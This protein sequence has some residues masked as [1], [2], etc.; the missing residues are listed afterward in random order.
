MIFILVLLSSIALVILTVAALVRY[1]REPQTPR[2]EIVA[3]AFTAMVSAVSLLIVTIVG[4]RVPVLY[5]TG[6]IAS[7]LLP[8][9]LLK[10]AF[11][12]RGVGSFVR[13]MALPGM[14]AVWTL[15]LIFGPRPPS[16][17]AV[18][19]ALYYTAAGLLSTI[20]FIGAAVQSHGAVRMRSGS[21]AVGTLFYTTFL[22]L[23]EGRVVTG[24][25]HATIPILAAAFDTASAFAFCVGLSPPQRLRLHWARALIPALRASLYDGLSRTTIAEIA[26][27]V[28]G[29]ARVA[30]GAVAAGLVLP[31]PGD[32]RLR[33]YRSDADASELESL[34]AV[35]TVTG[36]TVAYMVSLAMAAPEPPR[37]NNPDAEST[38]ALQGALFVSYPQPPLFAEEAQSAL[39]IAAEESTPLL[40]SAVGSYRLEH[41]A[42]AL[43]RELDDRRST[44]RARSK[45]LSALYRITVEA[46]EA[47]SIDEPLMRAI[48][49]LCEILGFSIGH[50]F[51][52]SSGMPTIMGVTPI[53]HIDE[54]I[55]FADFVNATNELPSLTETGGV[56][57][58]MA[59]RYPQWYSDISGHPGFLRRE[60]AAGVGI[61]TG[62]F[63]PVLVQGTV[64]AVIEL[65][66]QHR[67]P[68][69]LETVEF[70]AN[71]GVQLGRVIERMQTEAFIRERERRF[72][73][74]FE[75]QPGYCFI[76]DAEGNIR[77]NNAS[78]VRG[79][80]Y[81]PNEL[82]GAPLRR[83]FSDESWPSVSRLF[84]R[85]ARHGSFEKFDTEVLTRDGSSRYVA[86]NAATLESVEHPTAEEIIVALTDVTEERRTRLEW[87]RLFELTLDLVTLVDRNGK[88][89]QVNPAWTRTL[90]WP[91][92]ELI[93]HPV[94][95]FLHPEDVDRTEAAR[96]VILDGESVTNYDSR[97][98]K[99]DGSYRWIS[100]SSTS[101][102][103]ESIIL[104][105]GRDVTDERRLQ[106]RLE[107]SEFL[108][109][110]T[111]E[112]AA[113]GVAHVSPDGRF[114]RVNRKF[115]EM[116]GYDQDAMTHITSA[117]LVPAEE[118]EKE[119]ESDER[120]LNGKISSYAFE[121]QYRTAAGETLWISE[122]VSLARS[123]ENEPEYFIV[124]AVDITARKALE[125]QL[126]VT[127]AELD[128]RVT[129]RTEHLHAVNRE[130]E[131]FSYSV[132]H[133]LRAPL[134]AVDG[135]S[136]AIAEDYDELLDETGRDYLG[137]IRRETQ[138]MGRLIDD[139]LSL[140]RLSR[141]EIQRVK[142]DMTAMAVRIIDDLRRDTPERQAL[143]AV[144]DGLTVCADSRL[145]EILLRN[146]LGN[147]WKF[148]GKRSTAQIQIGKGEGGTRPE[149]Y[150]RDNG[151]GFNMAYVDKLFGAFQRL[152][153]TEDFEGTGVGLATVQ[154]IA[155]RHGGAVRAEGAVD[156]GATFYFE[157]GDGRC[158]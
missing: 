130:L 50:A 36:G 126:R 49:I 110:N 143:V 15:A 46:N 137:R 79:L 107:E 108:F 106:H 129:E 147:A 113:A 21:M 112:Q 26:G 86:L 16:P 102:P 66:S 116:L 127:N 58:V 149:F 32:R 59:L 87:N 52:P 124:V 19:T 71:V 61:N 135:F 42:S 17:A 7:A 55:A 99:S 104:A 78:A 77:D 54:D 96:R 41:R 39:S 3:T 119:R 142:V 122:T 146:L 33:L 68:R 70:L 40:Q 5:T 43:E 8:F 128:R 53:W 94:S 31:D 9:F 60:A 154:R 155:H 93:D 56:G 148:T 29:A 131:S 134:R 37:P 48:H 141:S 1:R 90:G 85:L 151:A 125:E 123:Q 156:N 63:V 114:L 45:R 88:I 18:V 57:D 2:L 92:W 51:A 64:A 118:L 11:R 34:D 97:F 136:Q 24:Q 82:V 84:E 95:E 121:R 83:L 69:D 28:C 100:W 144:E 76:L 62:V 72:R 132:S 138:R 117:D 152:H 120:L 23:V 111:F 101:V 65:F 12:L 145:V 25:L 157:L 140:G 22:V 103:G 27:V 6:A 133:D 81:S 67:I 139:L 73:S 13:Y 74:F 30:T 98:R 20:V 158:E 150:V 14:L 115:H 105:L 44:L 109:R 38:P 89:K 47:D 10:L 91:A 153:A 35:S 75:S 4:F 80:G